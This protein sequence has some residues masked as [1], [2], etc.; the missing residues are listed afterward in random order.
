MTIVHFIL[1]MLLRNTKTFFLGNS[2]SCE[3]KVQPKQWKMDDLFDPWLP[4]FT[5]EKHKNL[6]TIICASEKHKNFLSW[7]LRV[8][9]RKSTTKTMK[10]GRSFWSVTTIIYF[11]ET[12]KLDYHYLCFWETQKLSFLET[13]GHVKEKYDQNNERW[14]IFLI[15]DFHYLLRHFRTKAVCKLVK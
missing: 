10:D 1:S 12:Q 14:T 5:S 3:G 15:H 13:Q 7:K 11:W 9:W 8:M 2:G 4:L 6:T